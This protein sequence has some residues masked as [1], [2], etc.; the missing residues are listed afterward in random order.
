MKGPVRRHTVRVGPANEERRAPTARTWRRRCRPSR[1]ASGKGQRAV[2][3][4]TV[5]GR[6]SRVPA[7]SPSCWPRS[8]TP[9]G[10]RFPP[11]PSPTRST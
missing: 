1:R 5:V 8:P 7:P 3:L 4:D 10:W 2:H 6:R 9:L 11:S